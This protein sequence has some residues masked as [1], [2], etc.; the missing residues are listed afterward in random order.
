M[1]R[2]LAGADDQLTIA[3]IPY[4]VRVPLPFMRFHNSLGNSV[5]HRIA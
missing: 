5:C 4:E 3:T 2:K 1:N